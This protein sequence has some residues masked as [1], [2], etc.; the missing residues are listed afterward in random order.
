MRIRRRSRVR[1]GIELAQPARERSSVLVGLMRDRAD[2]E[3]VGDPLVAALTTSRSTA[4]SRSSSKGRPGL[5]A[6]TRRRARVGRPGT[7]PRS[8]ASSITASASAPRCAKLDRDVPEDHERRLA[9]RSTRAI[10]ATDLVGGEPVERLGR[11]RR[12]RRSPSSSGIASAAARRAPRPPARPPPASRASRRSARRRPRARSAATSSRV[13]LPVPGAE[14]EHRRTSACGRARRR[15]VEQLRPASRA[16][17]ARTPRA[18][19]P[20]LRRASLSQRRRARTAAA[21]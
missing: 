16:G 18:A 2:R 20:K 17:R 3:Q 6:A 5:A 15:P 21:P 19:R 9:G 4:A 11:R 13:S 1:A 14:V 7:P 10:S 12:R 8:N